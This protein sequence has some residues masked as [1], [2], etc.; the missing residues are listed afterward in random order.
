MP[1][2]ERVDEWERSSTPI[3]SGASLFV[4]SGKDDIQFV[5]FILILSIFFFCL[6][7]R[8]TMLVSNH[9]EEKKVAKRRKTGLYPYSAE[10]KVQYRFTFVP[11]WLNFNRKLALH[12]RAIAH[13]C[14]QPRHQFSQGMFNEGG[15]MTIMTNAPQDG[16]CSSE[17]KGKCLILLHRPNYPTL[18][19]KC[20]NCGIAMTKIFRHTFLDGRLIISLPSK[21]S[22]K[23]SVSTT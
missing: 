2:V 14:D 11:Q 19:R 18:L 1:T 3:P 15:T 13:L 17:K 10:H 5:D 23:K 16:Q 12:R 21:Q 6:Q 9:N 4:S 7:V 22:K 8:T 20:E